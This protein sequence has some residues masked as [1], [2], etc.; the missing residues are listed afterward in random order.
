MAIDPNDERWRK[1][2]REGFLAAADAVKRG[3]SVGDLRAFAGRELKEWLDH[4]TARKWPP[5]IYDTR[6]PTKSGPA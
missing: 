2:F 4:P 5:R 3:Y 1:G 6:K